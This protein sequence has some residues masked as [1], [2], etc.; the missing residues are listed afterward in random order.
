M[1]IPFGCRN[2]HCSNC[3]D[4]RGGPVGHETSEC[5]YRSGMAVVELAETMPADKK[6]CYY[7]AVIDR[8][9]VDR[10]AP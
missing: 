10:E 5:A 3:G 9:F 1:S 7:D 2:T 8:Y 6:S 4:E